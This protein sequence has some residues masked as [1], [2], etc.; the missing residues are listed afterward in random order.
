[1][2]REMIT[3]MPILA[4][5]TLLGAILFLSSIFGAALFWLVRQVR[6]EE[7]EIASLRERIR[8]DERKRHE[9]KYG[10]E[11]IAVRVRDTKR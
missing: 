3:G 6:R 10:E 4:L 2:N 9:K 8:N 5:V 7:G 1:M 11:R